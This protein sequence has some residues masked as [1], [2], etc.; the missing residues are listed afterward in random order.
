MKRTDLIKGFVMKP[1]MEKLKKD[2]NIKS[3]SPSSLFVTE[4]N[5]GYKVVYN[6]NKIV[7]DFSDLDLIKD[8]LIE[9]KNKPEYEKVWL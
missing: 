3:P 2:Y 5:G 1:V 4:S 9:I 8:L 6:S 7:V